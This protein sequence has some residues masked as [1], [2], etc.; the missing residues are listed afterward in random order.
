MS[1]SD[2]AKSIGESATLVLNAKAAALRSSG[3]PVIH[4][5]GGEPKSKA[6]AGAIAKAG[7]VLSSGEVRY[8]P[9][10]GIPALKQALARKL[11]G[12]PV[13]VRSPLGADT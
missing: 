4:L 13:N 11:A 1:I 3:E 5:G 9:S 6:P 10:S 2:I 8:A 12:Y 7:E